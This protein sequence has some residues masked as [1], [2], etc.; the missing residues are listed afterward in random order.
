VQVLIGFFCNKNVPIVHAHASVR[1]AA[2]MMR[3]RQSGYVVIIL[4]SKGLKKPLGILTDRDIVMRAVADRD[5]LENVLVE[6]LM[7]KPLFTVR[8]DDTI[9]QASV[10]MRI[11]GITRLPVVD[12]KNN[13]VGV[14]EVDDL[15]KLLNAELENLTK[16]SYNQLTNE[17][18][19]RLRAFGNVYSIGA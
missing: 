2:L 11:N 1:E 13:L 15:L 8:H 10:L 12:K 4:E 3:Q 19:K 5:H 9:Y 16:L 14:V 7:S 17:R 18:R 6:D